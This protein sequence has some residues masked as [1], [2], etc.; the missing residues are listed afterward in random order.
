MLTAPEHFIAIDIDGTLYDDQDHYNVERF[1]KDL[2]ELTAKNIQ[3]IVAT[4]NSYDAVQH[5]FRNSPAVDTFVA[6]NG[7]RIVVNGQNVIAV[8]HKQTVLQE[9]L[10]FIHQQRLSPD[11]L[12]L[13]GSAATHIGAEYKNVPVPF[14]PH[15]DYF[16]T[17]S[18][19]TEPIYNLN[20][21]WFRQ[22]P[23]LD[24]ILKVA[25]NINH[26]FAGQ[27]KATYSGAYGI[28]ILPANVDKAR[29]LSQL[30]SRYYHRSLD[31][32]TAFGDSSNDMEMIKEV[33]TGVAMLNATTDLKA[34]A[35]R[36]TQFDNN[37]DGLLNEIEQLF[38]I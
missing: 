23:S 13:S 11:L 6:E 17:I 35:Q 21:N 16:S 8:V 37:H 24:W 32:V 25:D 26:R 15:H 20:I 29:G 1:N 31:D 38:L 19:I 4:G 9:L 10:T 7:G 33:G 5:I 12:S 36:I 22:Q 2:Q 30:I 3:L 34:A 18:T 14:Y 28:D 27:V